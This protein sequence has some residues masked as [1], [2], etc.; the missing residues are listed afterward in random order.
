MHKK[1]TTNNIFYILF[2]VSYYVQGTIPVSVFIRWHDLTTVPLTS[3]VPNQAQ[4]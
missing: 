2:L 1:P 4:K 3:H